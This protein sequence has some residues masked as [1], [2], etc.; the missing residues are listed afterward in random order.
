MGLKRS[1][2]NA[3]L[4]LSMGAPL[5]GCSSVE[6]GFASTT[7]ALSSSYGR[8]GP[9]WG[10]MGPAM[11]TDS[12]TVQRIRNPEAIEAL[13]ALQPEPGDVWP[14]EEGR[15]ATLANPEEALRGIQP[16]DQPTDQPPRRRRGSAGAF[17]SQPGIAAPV[18]SP[19]FEGPAPPPRANRADVPRPESGQIFQS[20]QGPVTTTGGSGRVRTTISPQGSGLAIQDGSTTTLIGPGGN[21]QQV[22]T[23][24]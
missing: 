17:D 7:G 11:P 15:R 6:S 9:S 23:P 5:I 1:M 22:P 8:F 13:P 18:I 3:V 21:V 12:L 10:G 4:L 20:D 16:T 19:V 24:R 2:L 14:R